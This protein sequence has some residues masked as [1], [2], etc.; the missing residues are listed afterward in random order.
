MSCYILRK[1]KQKYI[2]TG[3]ESEGTKLLSCFNLKCLILTYIA[4]A[5][6]IGLANLPAQMTEGNIIL[7]TQEKTTFLCC[8]VLAKV[9]RIHRQLYKGS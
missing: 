8:F 4:V 5:G 9:S 3:K 1:R 2:I 7:G 6:A